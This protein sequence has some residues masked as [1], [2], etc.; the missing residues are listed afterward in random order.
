MP[1]YA[2]SVSLS[3]DSTVGSSEP[4][5]WCTLPSPPRWSNGA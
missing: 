5:S 1:D 4:K 2:A 3:E